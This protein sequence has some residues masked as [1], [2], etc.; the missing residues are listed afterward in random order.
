MDCSQA[1]DALHEEVTKFVTTLE[2]KTLQED[3][4]FEAYQVSMLGGTCHD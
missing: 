3:P 1:M 4:A 2:K